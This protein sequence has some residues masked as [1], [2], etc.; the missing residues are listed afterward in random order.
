MTIFASDRGSNAGNFHNRLNNLGNLASPGARL[1]PAKIVEPKAGYRRRLT[2]ATIQRAESGM[3][4]DR[5]LVF[6][7]SRR[8]RCGLLGMTGSYIVAANDTARWN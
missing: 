2:G 6:K 4:A 3:T 7:Q 8:P 1:G 5:A